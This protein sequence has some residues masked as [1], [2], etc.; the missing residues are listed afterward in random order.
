MTA[1][2]ARWRRASIAGW[3][4]L[5]LCGVTA[6]VRAST[7]AP[8]PPR[9]HLSD[10]ERIQVGRDAAAQEPGWREQSLHN[11]PGD[12]WSQDDDFSASE[13]SWV[14]GEAQR[15]DVPVE[16]VFRA[17][18]EELRSSGPVRPPRKATTAPCKPR[19]FYD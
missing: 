19:A 6:G 3:L 10:A 5:T 4:T 9:K 2:R 13:R 18:D 7:V 8:A 12:A 16:E 14:T 1:T 17:I 15:R 11:F